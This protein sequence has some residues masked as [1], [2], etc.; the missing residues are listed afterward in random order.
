[1]AALAPSLATMVTSYSLYP[2]KG[3]SI[4]SACAPALSLP[5][6]PLSLPCSPPWVARPPAVDSWTSD[7][8]AAPGLLPT[9]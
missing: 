4:C 9:T 8:G 5:C 3:C 7:A 1:M 2:S 6:F